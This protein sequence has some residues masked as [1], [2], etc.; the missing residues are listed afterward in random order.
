MLVL[1]GRLR[2]DGARLDTQTALNPG[3]QVA[4]DS[5]EWDGMTDI[6]R[7]TFAQRAMRLPSVLALRLQTD[8]SKNV[9]PSAPKH[10]LPEKQDTAAVSAGDPEGQGVCVCVR[11]REVY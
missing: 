3:H 8:K 9:A 7:L 4:M 5:T 11:E 2:C 1:D 6:A 10:A